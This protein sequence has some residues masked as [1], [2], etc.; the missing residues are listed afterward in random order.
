MTD[1]S[2][3]VLGAIP[4]KLRVIRDERP[5]G[6]PWNPA[7]IAGQTYDIEFPNCFVEMHTQKI[8]IDIHV[9]MGEQDDFVSVSLNQMGV[10]KGG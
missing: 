3:Q 9:R 5:R 6:L 7:L 1:R 2:A 10:V 4:L 8:I